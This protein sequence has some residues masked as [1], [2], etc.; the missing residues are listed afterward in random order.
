MTHPRTSSR[1]WLAAALVS[2]A[3]GAAGADDRVATASASSFV[4]RVA[5][6]VLEQDW[7][8]PF[9]EWRARHPD[10][11]CESAP[12]LVI[13]EQLLSERWCYSCRVARGGVEALVRF[14]VAPGAEELTCRLLET[15]FTSDAPTGKEQLHAKLAGAIGDRLSSAAPSTR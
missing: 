11:V 10:A 14:H 9:E 8:I 5:D 4:E 12:S 13:Y 6:V 2:V 1:P 7:N 15:Q 3:A